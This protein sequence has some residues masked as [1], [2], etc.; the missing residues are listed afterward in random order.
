MGAYHIMAVI[1]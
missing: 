1:Q